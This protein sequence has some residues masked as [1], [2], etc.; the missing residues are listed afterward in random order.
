MSDQHQKVWS[1]LEITACAQRAIE[2]IL[3]GGG[4]HAGGW[5]KQAVAYGIYVGW[6]QLTEG[7]RTPTDDER[8]HK[9]VRDGCVRK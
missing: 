9:L 3:H 1:Y 7:H 5:Q 8:L 4:E 2:Q 6:S